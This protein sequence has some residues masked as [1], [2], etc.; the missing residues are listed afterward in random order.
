MQQSKKFEIYFQN[1]VEYIYP[2]FN[3]VKEYKYKVVEYGNTGV[4]YKYLK[5]EP[6]YNTWVSVLSYFQPL[7]LRNFKYKSSQ[8]SKPELLTQVTALQE[9]IAYLFNHF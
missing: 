2:L 7:W 9:K 4:K 3:Q 1:V 5:C 6:K 8:K